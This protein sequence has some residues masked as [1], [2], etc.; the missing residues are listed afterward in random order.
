MAIPTPRSLSALCQTS[1]PLM[2]RHSSGKRMLSRV[3]DIVESD[4]WNSFDHFHR[5]TEKLV[6]CYREAGAVAEVEALQTGG[7][8]GSGRWI[9]QEAADVRSATVD[10]VHPFKERVLD[11]AEN[12]WHVVQWSA[13]TPAGGLRAELVVLDSREAIER[14][15]K[16]RLRNKIVL[17]NGDPRALMELLADRGA[18]GVIGDRPVPNYPDALA[19]TKFGWG[20]IPMSHA[21]ARLVGFVLS[22][23]QGEA[24]RKKAQKFGSLELLLTA[25][26]RKYV[27]HHDVVSG[28]VRGADDPQDEVWAIAHSA[29][30]GAADNASGVA[31]TLEIAHLLEELIASGQLA[32]PRRS[33]RLLNAYECYEIG[34]AHV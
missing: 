15:P 5:T 6:R 24:L 10:V 26:I 27:G 20:A 33:I 21:T 2:L 17:T 8:I 4:R 13:A 7:Q 23:R 22:Q 18:V 32:R 11:Y 19:W 16:G 34:R 14:L 9:I 31:L 3:A 12:P 28:I 25:D 1:L 30:P 29:E